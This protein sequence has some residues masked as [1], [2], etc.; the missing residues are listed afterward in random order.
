[1]V[2]FEIV[3]VIATASLNQKLNLNTIGLLEYVFHDEAVYG[4]HA[5]YF[6]SPEMKGTV[7]LFSSGKM[8]TVGTGRSRATKARL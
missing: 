1:M 3:N 2:R 8:I 4:G 6:R 5:A 7:S